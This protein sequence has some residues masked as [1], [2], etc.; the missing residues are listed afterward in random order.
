[1]CRYSPTICSCVDTIK[2]NEL[3]KENE[4]GNRKK[5][6]RTCTYVHNRIYSK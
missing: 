5:E 4:K 2:R 1:M 6:E 3:E